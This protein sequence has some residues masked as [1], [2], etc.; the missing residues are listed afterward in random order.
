[1]LH[2]ETAYQTPDY[3]TVD[4]T[5]RHKASCQERHVQQC[6]TPTDTSL[7]QALK[8]TKLS[9]VSSKRNRCQVDSTVDMCIH[10]A[11]KKPIVVLLPLML[12]WLHL[13]Y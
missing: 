3:W 8:Q 2:V 1:M 6:S 7:P 5:E 9:G 11:S 10:Q 4:A 12:T 13:Q